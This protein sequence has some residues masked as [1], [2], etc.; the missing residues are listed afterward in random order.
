MPILIVAAVIAFWVSY[1]I[2]A[3]ARKRYGPQSSAPVLWAIG[4]FCI[5]IIFL[6]AY[7]IFRPAKQDQRRTKK[8]PQC[9]ETIRIEALKCRFC[10]FQFDKESVAQQI[11]DTQAAFSDEQQTRK[12]ATY[13]TWGNVLVVVG[14]V[15][16]FFLLSTVLVAMF[17]E[18]PELAT[19]RTA[20]IIGSLFFLVLLS[21]I[22]ILAGIRLRRKAKAQASADPMQ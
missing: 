6:P 20:A 19:N 18:D 4:V 15:V 1:A 7:F 8:C 12:S 22:P 10:G 3:D 13:K 5:M 16:G 9:A 2:H 14:S 11:I 21:L 17:S